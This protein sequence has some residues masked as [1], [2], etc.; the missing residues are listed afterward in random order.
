MYLKNG[1]SV[2]KVRSAEIAKT[3]HS[4]VKVNCRDSKDKV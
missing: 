3:G 2:V 1:S 4:V